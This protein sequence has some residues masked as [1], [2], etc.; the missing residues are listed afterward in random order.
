MRNVFKILGYIFIGIVLLPIVAIGLYLLLGGSLFII[1]YIINR[2]K[3]GKTNP[4]EGKVC[5]TAS[6]II[7]I[8]LCFIVFYFYKVTPFS[9]KGY[10]LTQ[11]VTFIGL[12]PMCYYFFICLKN[13]NS[14]N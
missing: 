8:I 9:L 10:F 1:L 14:I 6:T 2:K 3:N 4:N 12:L 11:G 13:G 5:K 7:I